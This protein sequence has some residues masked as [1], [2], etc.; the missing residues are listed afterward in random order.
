MQRQACQGR[1][2]FDG[3]SSRSEGKVWTTPVRCEGEWCKGGCQ[4]NNEGLF[5][6]RAKVEVRPLNRLGEGSV[7]Q[8]Q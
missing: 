3:W 1:R 7:L 8:Y 5:L 2:V 6:A 4:G